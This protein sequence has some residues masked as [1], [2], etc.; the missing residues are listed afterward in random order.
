MDT[1]R[2]LWPLNAL[3]LPRLPEIR[4]LPY[5]KAFEREADAALE[6]A[7]R[8]GEWPPAAD[9]P[10]D[11]TRTVSPCRCR[12]LGAR[13]PHSRRTLSAIRIPSRSHG[14]ARTAR[15]G[16]HLGSWLQSD[17]GIKSWSS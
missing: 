13:R 3:F 15:L 6:T 2:A 17:T 16:D 4:A 11:C 5:D 12:M 9:V 14:N 1:V 10:V 7:V 8:Q